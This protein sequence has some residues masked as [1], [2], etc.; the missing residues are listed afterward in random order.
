MSDLPQSSGNPE[1][2][3]LDNAQLFHRLGNE[4]NRLRVANNQLEDANNHLKAEKDRFRYEYDRLITDFKRAEDA[5]NHFR[6]ENDHLRAE[7]NGLK[8]A[9]NHFRAENNRLEA[10]N[11]LFIY[12][13]NRLRAENSRLEDANNQ[14]RAENNRLIAASGNISREVLNYYEDAQRAMSMLRASQNEF[15]ETINAHTQYPNL[16]DLLN[17]I[18]SFSTVDAD[19]GIAN[20]PPREDQSGTFVLCKSNTDVRLFYVIRTQENDAEP[21]LSA[22]SGD[23]EEIL[24]L[25]SVPNPSHLYLLIQ[26]LLPEA[27][28]SNNELT[29]LDNRTADELKTEIAHIYKRYIIALSRQIITNYGAIRNLRS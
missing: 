13:Y 28:F 18:L 11:N 4:N 27:T 25:T 10:A 22:V 21:S 7:N 6:A 17:D 5:K 19:D 24:R 9:K 1:I 26:K 20:I 29:L 2:D 15:R 3:A 16:R 14:L 8:D 23:M 12:E